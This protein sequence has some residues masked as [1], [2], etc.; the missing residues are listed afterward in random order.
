MTIRFTPAIILVIILLTSCTK[1]YDCVDTQISPAFVGYSSSDIDTFVI[2]K[3]KISDNFQTLLDTSV[4]TRSL[5]GHYETSNDTTIVSIS[6][7]PN[8]I[9]ADFDWQLYIPA[10]NKTVLISNIVS[11]KRKGKRGFGIFSMDP[12]SDC[13]NNIFSAKIDNQ[14]INFRNAEV[15]RP[16]IF[17]KN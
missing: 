6:I 17:I 1:E 13:I 3:F 11:E 4:I 8:P 14:H 15:E 7:S 12:G 10:K 2:R 16:V 5:S 9:K